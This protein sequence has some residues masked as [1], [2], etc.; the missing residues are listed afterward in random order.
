MFVCL[1]W[2]AM[3]ISTNSEE[4]TADMVADGEAQ[5]ISGRSTLPW[6]TLVPPTK[7]YGGVLNPGGTPKSNVGFILVKPVLDLDHGKVPRLT[8]NPA[9]LPPFSAAFAGDFNRRS[10]AEMAFQR[11]RRSVLVLLAVALVL[12]LL[13]HPKHQGQG[14]LGG[15]LVAMRSPVRKIT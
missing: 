14:G 15:W 3:F 9:H 4:R 10:P 1:L 11:R 8:V 7:E 5:Q 6:C 13:P 2:L 12:A